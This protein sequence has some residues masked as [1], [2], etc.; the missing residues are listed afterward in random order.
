MSKQIK[1]PQQRIEEIKNKLLEIGPMIPGK[2]SQRKRKNKNSRCYGN[3]WQI[4]YTYKAKSHTHYVLDDLVETIR[5]QNEAY[6]DFKKLI[7]EWIG[8]ALTIAKSELKAAKN[9][10]KITAKTQRLQPTR[11]KSK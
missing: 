6:R 8:L 9:K 4:G 10:L 11:Y 5:S 2:L 1:Q 7:D 3:Y